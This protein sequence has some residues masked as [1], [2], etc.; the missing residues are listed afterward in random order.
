MEIEPFGRRVV[1]RK[2]MEYGTSEVLS[3]LTAA[4]GSAV[5]LF[6]PQMSRD[7]NKQSV[8]HVVSHGPKCKYVKE[9]DRIVYVRHLGDASLLDENLLIMHEEDIIGRLTVD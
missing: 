7:P 2:D 5:K 4:D 6:A 8:G 3:E 1:V 9:G